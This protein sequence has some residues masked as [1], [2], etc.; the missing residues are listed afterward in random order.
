VING[1]RLFDGL[2]LHFE[3][4]GGVA[5]SRGD[6]GMAKPL[7]DRDDVNARAQQMYCGTVAHA[8][9]VQ[10]LGRK[11]RCHRLSPYAAFLE[12][13]AHAEPA[14]AGTTIITK[15]WI[16]A[17]RRIAAFGQQCTKDFGGLRPKRAQAL[18]RPL[19]N[20]R[21]CGGVWRC[22]SATRSVTIS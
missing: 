21:T 15:E 2:S 7:T 18:F 4:Q 19:P 22:A 9:G 6:T 12:D 1:L 10:T 5:V 16:V 8:V 14:K 17:E 13:V 11:C 20:K 3:I